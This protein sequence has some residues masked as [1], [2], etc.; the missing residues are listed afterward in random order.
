MTV[1]TCKRRVAAGSLPCSGRVPGNGPTYGDVQRGHAIAPSA[2]EAAFVV[3]GIRWVISTI[4]ADK[5]PLYG[6]DR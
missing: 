4:M 6:Q 5:C 1:I 3:P 2:G